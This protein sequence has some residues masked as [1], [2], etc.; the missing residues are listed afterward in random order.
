M[1]TVGFGAAQC[2]DTSLRCDVTDLNEDREVGAAESVH[3]LR[4][5]DGAV[6]SQQ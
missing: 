5:R 3:V 1:K 2:V 6:Q 4:V